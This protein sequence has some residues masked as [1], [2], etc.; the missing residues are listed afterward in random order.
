MSQSI[1]LLP[2]LFAL[3]SCGGE[4]YS[5]LP[6]NSQRVVSSGYELEI[7]LVQSS[8]LVST[9]EI[10]VLEPGELQVSLKRYGE[11]VTNEIVTLSSTV[12]ALSPGSGMILTDAM[13]EAS[14]KI[15]TASILGAGTVTASITP[16]QSQGSIS[17]SLHFTVVDIAV[18]GEGDADEGAIRIIM[19]LDSDT[20]EANTIRA[21]APGLVVSTVLDE[22]SEPLANTLVT[23][24]GTNISLNP[25]TGLVLTNALGQASISI[26]ANETIGVGNILATVVRGENSYSTTLNFTVA[27]PNIDIG[28]LVDGVFQA[29]ELALTFDSV[30]AGGT[31]S[32]SADI[33][34][35]SGNLFNEALSVSFE[36]PCSQLGLASLDTQVTAENGSVTAIY[37]ANGCLGSDRIRA[38]LD[39]GGTQFTATA[40][41]VVNA[42]SAGSIT[43]SDAI[44]EV[45]V[46][47]GAGGQGLFES[48]TV[49]FQ[50]LGSRGLPLANQV[51]NFELTT[52]VGGIILDPLTA[53]SDSDGKVY[54]TVASGSVS[55]SVVVVATLDESMISTQS[56]LLVISTGAP[57]NDSV[58]LSMAQYNPEAWSHD[59]ESVS[60][61]V[62]AS[63]QFNNPVPDGVR[64]SFTTEGGSVSPSCSIIN[65]ACSITWVSQNP[66]PSNGIARLLVTA[67]GGETFQDENGNG[68]FDD[69]DTFSDMSEAFRDDNDNGIRDATEPYVDFNTNNV[70]DEADGFYGG[71]TCE[72][73]VRCAPLAGAT[74]RDDLNFVMSGSHAFFEYEPTQNNSYA[75][76][77]L[78]MATLSDINGNSLP[79]GTTI[80]VGA[81]T[82]TLLGVTEYI[83][84]GFK[85]GAI[86]IPIRLTPADVESNDTITITVTTPKLI[87]SIDSYSIRYE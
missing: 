87:I 72:D 6:E 66:R 33:V 62:L 77:S 5:E 36:S 15:S 74:V 10:S 76:G 21:D 43:F 73:S 80:T 2:F 78:I 69:G 30:S 22:N 68:V 12:G 44:P 49:S 75:A 71:P 8:D 79:G 26:L 55:S 11:P 35:Q 14:I 53:T 67:T 28:T 81:E 60:V 4:R 46:L 34:D 38:V 51:V 19:T 82:G 57:D 84:D 23:F 61:S 7:A 86:N 20:D 40:E 56:G 47:K 27:T 39:F 41:L 13:G 1:L 52:S 17:V 16:A 58:S 9:S 64:F 54:T 83:I 45:I 85:L 32:V 63:D 3:F 59:N 70:F 31:V 37:R 18:G 48:S 65:G 29:G 24:T 50:V 25:N 42:D